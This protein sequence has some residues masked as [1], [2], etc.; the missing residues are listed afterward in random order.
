MDMGPIQRLLLL[1]A[2]AGIGCA[3]KLPDLSL[4]SAVP[5]G[6]RNTG[7]MVMVS[8]AMFQHE[9]AWRFD[10]VDYSVGVDDRG[11]VRYLATRSTRVVTREG[12][13]VGQSFSD[14]QR[15][16]GVRVGAWPG[17]GYVAVLPSGW[18][19]ALFIGTS[20]TEREP[21]AGDAVA[22]L[23]RGTAAGYAKD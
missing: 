19:A 15:V 8:P 10:G 4:G 16:P 21:M 17:W 18:N 6:A 14:V 5:E 9:W 2:A 11:K 23:F 22:M 7:A 3:A 13:H 20:M 1:A 12:V